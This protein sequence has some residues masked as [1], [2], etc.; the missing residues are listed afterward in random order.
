MLTI[1]NVISI[2]VL[3]LIFSCSRKEDNRY[4]IYLTHYKHSISINLP[5]SYDT[6]NIWDNYSD[7]VMDDR[8]CYRVQNS[9]LGVLMESGMFY[10]TDKTQFEQFTISEPGVFNNFPPFELKTWASEKKQLIEEEKGNINVTTDSIIINNK[11]FGVLKVIMPFK[12]GIDKSI[13]F[14]TNLDN[15]LIE[16]DFYTNLPNTE[17]FFNDAVASMETLEIKKGK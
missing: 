12:D 4:D 8:K 11:R 3:I 10:K 9:K 13:T 14:G 16:F 7:N 2:I 1:R 6:L 17:N 15:E 5:K